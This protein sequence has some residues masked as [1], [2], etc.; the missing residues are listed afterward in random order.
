MREAKMNILDESG[1]DRYHRLLYF[2]QKKSSHQNPHSN[3][4]A[5]GR[6]PPPGPRNLNENPAP[7]KLSK[8]NPK[9]CLLWMG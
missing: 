6:A 3:P 2:T 9:S 4:P 1:K 7:E 5:R 8:K